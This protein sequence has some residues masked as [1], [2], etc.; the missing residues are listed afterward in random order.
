[1]DDIFTLARD[2]GA[3]AA[4]GFCCAH[5]I[6]HANANHFQLL[7]S[8]YSKAC[9]IN[10]AYSDPENFDQVFDIFSTQSLTSAQQVFLHFHIV[11]HTLTM[12]NLLVSSN[13]NSVNSVPRMNQYMAPTILQT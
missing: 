9:I 12:S 1:M 7:F 8:L 4:V 3:V 6:N 2:G 10:P 11:D 5:L 13:I